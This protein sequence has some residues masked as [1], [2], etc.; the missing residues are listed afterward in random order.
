MSENILL[1]RLIWS[2]LVAGLGALATIAAHK[3]AA[4]VWQQIFDE[5]P[6]E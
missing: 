1:K 2:G 5:E 3:L 6:P 4:R